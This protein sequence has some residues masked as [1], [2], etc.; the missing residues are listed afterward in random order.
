MLTPKLQNNI[1]A[2]RG[3]LKTLLKHNQKALIWE[4]RS[5]H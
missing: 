4:A 3:T 5:T 2:G 1:G